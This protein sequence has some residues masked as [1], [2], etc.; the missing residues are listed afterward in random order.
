[1]KRLFLLFL[2]CILI[3][4]CSVSRKIL[5]D[6][7]LVTFVGYDLVEDDDQLIEAT[8]SIPIFQADGVIQNELFT[9]NGEFGKDL[10]KKF[11]LNAP[12]PIGN[13]KL[14]IALYGEAFARKGVLESTDVTQ[15]DPSVSANLKLAVYEGKISEFIEKQNVENQDLGMYVSKII[16]NNIDS[17][18]IPRTNI[19]LFLQ[20]HYAE[21]VDPFLPLFTIHNQKVKLKGLALFKGDQ[22]VSSIDEAIIFRFTM[23]KQRESNGKLIINLKKLN[24]SVSLDH[25]DSSRDVEIRGSSESPEISINLKLK[26]IINENYGEIK[27]LGKQVPKIEKAIDK[28]L[29]KEL[30]QIIKTFQEENIDPIGFGREAKAHFRDW[31][32]KKWEEIYPELKI[33]VNV[34]TDIIESGVIE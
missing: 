28:Q 15:R 5:D 32:L 1:M 24:T 23:L 9:E 2:V 4:G 34:K 8:I 11:M 13:G 18:I 26:G 16:E 21:G 22:M 19:H 20:S 33:S 14:E 10:E 3:S 25:I 31:E 12:K 6:I 7:S 30:L 29:R 27:S 17:E